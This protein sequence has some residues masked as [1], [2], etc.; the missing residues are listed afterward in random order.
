MTPYDTV[1]EALDN[2]GLEGQ[3]SAN[4]CMFQCPAHQD[5]KASLSVAEGDDGT[6]LLYCFAGCET[7]QIVHALDLEWGD[8]FVPAERVPVAYYTYETDARLPLIRVIRYAPKGFSQQHWDATSNV[9]VH[10]LNGVERVPYRLPQLLEDPTQ[11]VYVTEGEKDADT[12]AALGLVSTT[13]LGGAGKW[14]DEYARWFRDRDVVVVGDAD[15]PGRAGADVLA[16]HLQGVA[17]SIIKVFPR[18]GKDVTDHIRAGY[19]V[20]DLVEEG[21]GFDEF[22]PLDWETY[23]VPPTAWLLEPYVPR[24]GRVLAYGPKGSLKSLWAMW[25][26]AHVAR[27][28]GKVAYFSLEMLPSDTARRMKQLSPPKD[29]FLCFTQNFRLGSPSHLEKLVR[30]LKDFDLIVIDSWTAARAGMKDSAEQIAEL[31]T[32]FLL[33]LVKETG[34]AVLMLDNVGHAA[35]TD[36]GPVKP[37][38]ARGSSAK[39]DKVDVEFQFERPY[40]DNN[41]LTSITCRKMRL[42]HPWPMPIVVCTPS[43]RIEFFHAEVRDGQAVP[44]APLWPGLDVADKPEQVPWE[45]QAEAR[46]KD[47][48]G[49][50]R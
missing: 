20:D 11:R 4:G 32:T 18:V 31:D 47:K 12:L 8:L 17:A 15:D 46:L 35:I 38:H 42:D 21:N 36:K 50:L 6:V 22:G 23:E 45:E 10:G 37:D 49:T 39:G 29:R 25:L 26:G 14:R 5:D 16:R 19:A 7:D 28:G 40:E 43:D 33:P 34:A 9:W 30:G 3:P 27:E 48:F 1:L 44:G 24:G 2:A 41:Y 13:L